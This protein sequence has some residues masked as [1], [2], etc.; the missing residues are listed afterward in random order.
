MA[1]RNVIDSIRNMPFLRNSRGVALVAVIWVTAV[2]AI[3]ATSVATSSKTETDLSRNRVENARARALADAAVQRALLTLLAQH[4]TP[5]SRQAGADR[6]TAPAP[7]YATLQGLQAI[8]RDGTA[9]TWAFNSGQVRISVRLE[10]GKINL[11]T[12]SEELLSGLLRS[13]GL[14]ETDISR[15][16]DSILDFRDPDSERRA[17]GHETPDYASIGLKYGAK[18][19]NFEALDELLLVPGMTRSLFQELR[20]ALTVYS[21]VQGFNPSYAPLEAF[22]ALPDMD[23]QRAKALLQSRQ[24]LPDE[25][26][27]RSLPASSLYSTNVAPVMT[28]VA[29]ATTPD[30]ARFTREAIVALTPGAKPPFYIFSWE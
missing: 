8:R 12:N 6:S 1:V 23:E 11:N 17:Y 28:I 18:N 27:R 15:L 30:G 2:L 13:A 25:D 7:Q 9:Y 22:M 21:A 3:I 14:R 10:S 4:S 24:S 19:R 5:A 29:E 26:F 16:T 20:P